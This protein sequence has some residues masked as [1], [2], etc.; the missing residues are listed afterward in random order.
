MSDSR[1][2]APREPIDYSYSATDAQSTA[3][4]ASNR[5]ILRSKSIEF[6]PDRLTAQYDSLPLETIEELSSKIAVLSKAVIAE[7]KLRISEAK[8]NAQLT[9]SLHAAERSLAEKMSHIRKVVEE[10]I[11]AEEELADLKFTLDEYQKSP[12]LP[13]LTAANM[14]TYQ[15]P[16]SPGS[17]RQLLPQSSQP[18]G[19][20]DSDFSD[21]ASI[22]SRS[23]VARPLMSTGTGAGARDSISINTSKLKKKELE[24][25]HKKLMADFRSAQNKIFDLEETVKFKE[26]VISDLRIVSETKSNI[27]EKQVQEL[28]AG[29]AQIVFQMRVLDDAHKKLTKDNQELSEE[30]RKTTL[31]AQMWKSRYEETAFKLGE[32]EKKLSDLGSQIENLQ[33][34]L[35]K[36]TLESRS[37]ANKLMDMKK[38]N[39]AGGI[40]LATF[41]VRKVHRL[42]PPCEAQ[43]VVAQKPSGDLILDIVAFGRHKVEEFSSVREIRAYRDKLTILYT[44]REP[45]IL[46]SDSSETVARTLLSFRDQSAAAGTAVQ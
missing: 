34:E 17:K 11:K 31:D 12:S 8:H 20:E 44:F 39:T 33:S 15:G 16:F 37:L 26:T 45:D 36:M 13:V 22:S 6:A 14:T 27:F 32:R 38:K 9:E 40:L 24:D 3:R 29:K 5:P 7:R 42:L 25:E 41:P 18:Q 19:L 30:R 4:Y 43:L 23:T 46:E 1:L 35:S 28:E 10:K 21:T 2:L